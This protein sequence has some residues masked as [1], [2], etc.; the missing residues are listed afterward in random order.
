VAPPPV[1]RGGWPAVL[2]E[3]PDTP[4]FV[5]TCRVFLRT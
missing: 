5:D 2:Q 3:N 4:G 1:N